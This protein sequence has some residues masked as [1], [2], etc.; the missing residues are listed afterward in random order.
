MIKAYRETQR[1]TQVKPEESHRKGVVIIGV[2]RDEDTMR[3]LST[4]SIK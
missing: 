1:Q 3:I 4:E 2:K